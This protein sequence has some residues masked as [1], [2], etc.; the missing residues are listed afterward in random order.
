MLD[1]EIEIG[2]IVKPTDDPLGLAH[3]FRAD[4]V[5]GKKQKLE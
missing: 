4:A 2:V 1:L 3:H 5:A